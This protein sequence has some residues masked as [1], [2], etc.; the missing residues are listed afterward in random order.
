MIK[1][2]KPIVTRI[3]VEENQEIIITGQKSTT[4]FN[5]Y[6]LLL[7]TPT[8]L[9][10][11]LKYISDGVEVSETFFVEKG[12]VEFSSYI[13]EAYAG[14][15][16]DFPAALK[17]V[18]LMES[19]E[20]IGIDSIMLIMC[21][22]IPKRIYLKNEFIKIGVS[23]NYGGALD[24]FEV[25]T[26]DVA[27][28]KQDNKV[29]VG[30]GIANYVNEEAIISKNVNLLNCHDT[31][32]LVQQSFYGIGETPYETGLMMG[33]D[34]PYN[35]VMG[36][37]RTNSSSKIVDFKLL[38]DDNV[39]KLYAKCRPQD[40][41]HCNKP[42]ASYMEVIYSLD[43]T[44]IRVDNKFTDYSKYNHP[45]NG[46]EMPAFYAIEPLDRLWHYDGVLTSQDNLPFWHQRNT[47]FVSTES[48]WAWTNKERDGFGVGLFV[49][50][51]TSAVAG[52]YKHNEP[53]STVPCESDPTVYVAPIA[54]YAIP[55]FRP[56]EYS[57]IL[58]AGRLSKIRKTFEEKSYILPVFNENEYLK[59][60]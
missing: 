35:P 33:L 59:K 32:R 58:T 60:D 28:I 37:D 10:G 6:V 34:W 44:C 41:G 30:P 53:L 24:Y 45:N 22:P 56:L 19:S 46:Q 48:W 13:D 15:T 21:D 12:V 23:L 5:K 11:E 3:M 4:E 39:P 29:V 40:W 25:L 51:L 20:S 36:G 7:N 8:P 16:G 57:Y 54:R 31:G 26:D 2:S 17:F 18:K 43:G 42:T 27:A 14:K 47:R 50:G 55:T 52:I 1:I 49:P 38:K 9:M